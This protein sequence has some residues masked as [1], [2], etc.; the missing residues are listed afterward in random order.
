MTPQPTQ[1]DSRRFTAHETPT[2]GPK[3]EVRLRLGEASLPELLEGVDVERMWLT[4]E[5]GAYELHANRRLGEAR[6]DGTAKPGVDVL[7]SLL[8]EFV[9]V[10]DD[11]EDDMPR[12]VV[13]AWDALMSRWNDEYPRTGS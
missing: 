4:D 6:K 1:S 5:G 10:L 8:N 11:H 2:P 7:V 13:E 12:P 3:A 9:A